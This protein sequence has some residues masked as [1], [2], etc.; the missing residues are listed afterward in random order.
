MGRDSRISNL[1]RGIEDAA[2]IAQHAAAGR[3]HLVPWTPFVPCIVDASVY[4]DPALAP[5]AIFR[6][7]RYQ[8]AMWTAE[9]PEPFGVCVHL[10]IKT[11]DKAA[12][13][14]WRDFQRIK[15]E[16]VGDE[17]EGVEIYPAES[18]LVDNANQYH[19]FVFRDLKLPFGFV[20]RLVSDGGTHGCR[21]RPF[22]VRPG[23]CLDDAAYQQR[24][25]ELLDLIPKRS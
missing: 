5:D 3:W 8:V 21:Q 18:R 22:D 10:S 7:S 1:L 16:L 15:N 2:Q 12:Y 13:H 6:N 19:L 20:G 25:R 23:D 11:H 17:Y 24:E 14:D 4:P 9:A